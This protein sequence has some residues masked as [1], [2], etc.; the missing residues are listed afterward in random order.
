[1]SGEFWVLIGLGSII[2]LWGLQSLWSW[3]G[4][5]RQLEQIEVAT[6]VQKALVHEQ[7]SGWEPDERYVVTFS[8]P[9]GARRHFVVTEAQYKQVHAGQMGQLLTRGSRFRSF[10]QTSTKIN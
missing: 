5:R 6:V 2:V 7:G 10:T 8:L 1:M 4:N 9:D 3:W